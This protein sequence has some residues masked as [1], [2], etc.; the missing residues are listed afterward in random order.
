MTKGYDP[1]NREVILSGKEGNFKV[2][3]PT[4]SFVIAN[5]KSAN[6]ARKIFDQQVTCSQN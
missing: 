1:K 3:K 6:E 5:I 2:D 4:T